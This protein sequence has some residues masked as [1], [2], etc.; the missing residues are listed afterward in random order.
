MCLWVGLCNEASASC[1]GP[2]FIPVENV[3]G[4]SYLVYTLLFVFLLV[5]LCVHMFICNN[6]MDAQMKGG[7]WHIW[8]WQWVKGMNWSV[9]LSLCVIPVVFSSLAPLENGDLYALCAAMLWL[10][11]VK[12]C[13]CLGDKERVQSAEMCDAPLF[14]CVCVCV[15]MADF[16]NIWPYLK[17]I[18]SV[19]D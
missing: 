13:D 12:C 4:E 17:P 14:V 16:R 3:L 7:R 1:P 5:H 18:Q 9:C 15:Q 6:S 8:L 10:S 11:Q 2:C 19:I